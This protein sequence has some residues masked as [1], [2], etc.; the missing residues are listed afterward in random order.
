MTAGMPISEPERQQM[1]RKHVFSVNGSS[2]FLDVV[3]T[4]LEDERYNITTTNF[5]PRTFEQI[6]SLQPDLLI[7]DIVVGIQSG[8]E[9]LEA[10]ARD[11]ETAAIPVI[12]CSTD[13]RSLDEAERMAAMG[14][15]RRY[16][17]KPFDIEQLLALVH[18]L[19]GEA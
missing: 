19:I 6:A 9:L 17:L 3:R 7:I 15:E 4:L 5:V 14:S 16:L 8:W 18:E 2:A 11:A 1:R 13:D 12:V 10:L